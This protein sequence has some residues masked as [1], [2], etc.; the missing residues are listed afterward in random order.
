MSAQNSASHC[1]TLSQISYSN[2]SQLKLF[3]VWLNFIVRTEI[4]SYL[5]GVYDLSYE[6]IGF[7]IYMLIY[8][9]V[10]IDKVVQK[11]SCNF[12]NNITHFVF[13]KQ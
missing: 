12:S 10:I 5:I 3:Y 9:H 8:L 13:V 4:I 1:I 6:L 2:L 11:N 7:V